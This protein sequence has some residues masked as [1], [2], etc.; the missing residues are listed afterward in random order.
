[1]NVLEVNVPPG[2]MQA[3]GILPLPHSGAL[4]LGFDFRTL[5]P[6]LFSESRAGFVSSRFRSTTVSGYK[7]RGLRTI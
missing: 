6:H 2:S 3:W 7:T 1:M 4:F 5:L